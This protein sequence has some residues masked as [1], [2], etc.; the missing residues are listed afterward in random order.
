MAD[1]CHP[2]SFRRADRV[3]ARVR[4]EQQGHAARAVA[5]MTAELWR[6][7]EQGLREHA[8]FCW[9][10]AALSFLDHSCSLL[11]IILACC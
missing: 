2:A 3:T 4:G 10:V 5:A 9:V 11:S 6:E 1:S 8:P 7:R